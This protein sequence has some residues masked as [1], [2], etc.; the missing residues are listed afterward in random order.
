MQIF[1]QAEEIPQLNFGPVSLGL[2]LSKA[3]FAYEV[4]KDLK[5][6]IGLATKAVEES[7]GKILCWVKETNNESAAGPDGANGRPF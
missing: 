2:E 6:A 3:V 5:T 7:N 1:V 4:K